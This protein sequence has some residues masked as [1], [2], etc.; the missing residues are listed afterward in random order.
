MFS[1]ELSVSPPKIEFEG[2]YVEMQQLASRIWR[3]SHEKAR[4]ELVQ[5]NVCEGKGLFQKTSGGYRI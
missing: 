5:I 4:Q 2:K 3:Q 1:A